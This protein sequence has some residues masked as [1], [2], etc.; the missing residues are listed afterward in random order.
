MTLQEAIDK[1][2]RLAVAV[3][4]DHERLAAEVY[5]LADGVVFLDVGWSEPYASSFRAHFQ[6][7]QVTG[8]GPWR[9]GEWTIREVDPETDD[10]Y[11]REW[12]RWERWKRE[13]K[14]TREKGRRYAAQVLERDV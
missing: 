3:M 11:V 9:V 12:A 2:A 10:D 14:A 6:P 8:S 7:G 5:V 13:T 4:P 1:G